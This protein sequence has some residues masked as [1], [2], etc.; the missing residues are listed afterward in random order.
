MSYL[1]ALDFP[2]FSSPFLY[3]F[4]LHFSPFLYSV[5]SFI[6][7]FAFHLF[8]FNCL[9]SF[10]I[11][12]QHPCSF[13]FSLSFPYSPLTLPLS[14][15]SLFLSTPCLFIHPGFLSSHLLSS[16]PLLSSSFRNRQKW[17]WCRV[18]HRWFPCV[19][20]WS[21][22]R[23]ESRGL[24]DMRWLS[25]C[26]EVRGQQSWRRPVARAEAAAQRLLRQALWCSPMEHGGG[27]TGGRDGEKEKT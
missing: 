19:T 1:L 20:P 17:K 27:K 8:L 9:L 23:A 3:F 16:F 22:E 7:L 26:D 5:I 6:S 15:S 4:L 25:S 21:R 11:V 13:I 2:L 24:W 14:L 18:I 10:P 12:S